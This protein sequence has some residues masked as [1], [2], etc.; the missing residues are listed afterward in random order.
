MAGSC[1]VSGD[2]KIHDNQV[3]WKPDFETQTSTVSE[4]TLRP[5]KK[6]LDREWAEHKLCKKFTQGAS[7]IS[8]VTANSEV[9]INWWRQN[10]EGGLQDQ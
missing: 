2:I 8:T 6:L 7:S 5:K 3:D 9:P 10:P 4:W 1:C